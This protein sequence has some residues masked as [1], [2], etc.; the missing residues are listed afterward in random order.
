[1][2]K[3]V[4]IHAAKTHFSKLVEEVEGGAEIIIARAGKAVA[5]LV[6]IEDELP[7]KRQFGFGKHLVHVPDWEAFYAA[8]EEIRAMFNWNKFDDLEEK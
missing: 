6:P 4:N 7:V 1:M 5:K 3:Q 2:D 8:D